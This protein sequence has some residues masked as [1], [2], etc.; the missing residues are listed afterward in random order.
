MKD[1]TDFGNF[2]S[3]VLLSKPQWDSKQF[4]RHLKKEWNI[5]FSPSEKNSETLV[6]KFGDGFITVSFIPTP[7][8]GDEAENYA[9]A[10]YLW[11]DAEKQVKS[12]KAYILVAVTGNKDNILEKAK[13]TTKLVDACLKQDNVV[14][15]Y[16][17]GAVY[18][19]RLY[20]QISQVLRDGDL[21]VPDWIWFGIARSGE[22]H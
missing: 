14:A 4:I 16:A 13:I 12:H 19:P 21:P 5:E 9:K 22:T 1:N 7:I 8:P 15:V 18:Q 6:E 2:I 10:N 17:D 3:F 20:H 11:P